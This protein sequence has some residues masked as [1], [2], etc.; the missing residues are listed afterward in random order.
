MVSQIFPSVE[1]LHAALNGLPDPCRPFPRFV[2]ELD[3]HGNKIT[4]LHQLLANFPS[5]DFLTISDNA[6]QHIPVREFHNGSQLRHLNLAGN[7]LQD[8]SDIANLSLYS[9]LRSLQYTLTFN[10]KEDEASR[11][12]IIKHLPQL[13]IVNKTK[14]TQQEREDAIYFGEPQV[15]KSQTLADNVITLTFLSQGLRIEKK[16]LRHQTIKQLKTIYARAFKLP[17]RSV[18]A[19]VFRHGNTTIPLTNDLAQLSYYDLSSDGVV[20]IDS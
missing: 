16:V 20:E 11:L 15:K 12:L 13:D 5:V 7:P 4:N 10:T 3:L 9:N 14:V 8:L 1:I 2:K 6:I 18:S 17:P 19:L